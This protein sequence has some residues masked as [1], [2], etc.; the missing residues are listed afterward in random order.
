MPKQRR[1]HNHAGV[2]APLVHLQIRAAGEGHMDFHQNFAVAHARD[3]YSFNLDV[4]FAVEDG[5]RHLAIHSW[6]PSPALPGW[7]TIFIESGRGWAARFSASTPLCSGKRWLISRS[8]SISRFMTNRTD[9]SCRSTDALYDPS[10]AFSS[11]HT[12]AGSIVA[13]LRTVCAN[14]NTRPPGRVASMAGRI[15][16]LPPTAKITAS[17]PRPSVIPRT[18]CPAS[19]LEASIVSFRPNLLAIV[20]LAGYKSEVIT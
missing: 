20:S 3:R 19:A 11:T 5:S 6:C 17:A 8:R 1:R 10:K 15:R 4:F 12:A 9:S 7:M 14:S 16:P 2:I 18:L 13:S